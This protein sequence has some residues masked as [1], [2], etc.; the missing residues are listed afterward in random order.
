MGN[1]ETVAGI[2][3]NDILVKTK[4]LLELLGKVILGGLALCYGLGLLMVNMYYSHYGAYSLSLFRLNYVIA[5]LW[6]VLP[7]ISMATFFFGVA[8]MVLAIREWASSKSIQA[9]F[10]RGNPTITKVTLSATAVFLIYMF[11]RLA[12]DLFDITLPTK[13]WLQ[14]ILGTFGIVFL[15]PVMWYSM[16]RRRQ[17]VETSVFAVVF[18]VYALVYVF[19]FARG[20][21]S[22]IPA[23]LGGGRTKGVQFLLEANEGDKKFFE[24]SGLRFYENSNW[25]RTAQLLF[26]TDDEYVFLVKPTEW[27]ES[28]TLSIKKD[29]VKSVL[30]QGLRGDGVSGDLPTSQEPTLPQ[31][32]IPAGS[33]Q[34]SPSP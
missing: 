22:K 30:Y 3:K 1:N 12:L 9:M 11:H 2:D 15:I 14:L 13:V 4:D 24:L 7:V 25:T 28:S 8:V 20:V 18:C 31:T 6:V 27:Q 19:L 26:A 10:K 29:A 17:P 21:Y 34:T 33:P 32:S 23:H 16:Y 5:G